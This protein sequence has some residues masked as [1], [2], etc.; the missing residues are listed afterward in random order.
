M[1]HLVKDLIKAHQENKPIHLGPL[2]GSAFKA[3]LNE[4]AAAR[5]GDQ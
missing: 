2:S 1:S 3:L 4:L 5:Q